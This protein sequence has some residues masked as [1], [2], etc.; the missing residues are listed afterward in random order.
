MKEKILKSILMQ[1][2]LLVK[3][4]ATDEIDMENFLKRY[5]NFYYYNALDGHESDDSERF[6][7]KKYSK[8]IKLHEDIQTKVV[9]LVYLGGTDGQFKGLALGRIS[10]SEGKIR[11]KQILNDY[12]IDSLLHNLEK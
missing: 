6:L 5:N 2:T 3:K 11:I 8:T 12:E 4:L 9:D 1:G 10:E 7:M